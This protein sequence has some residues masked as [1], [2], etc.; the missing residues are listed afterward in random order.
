MV[1]PVNNLRLI[2]LCTAVAAL[3][4]P[5]AAG[6]LRVTIERA[7]LPAAQADPYAGTDAPSTRDGSGLWWSAVDAEHAPVVTMD[8]GGEATRSTSSAWST[9]TPCPRPNPPRRPP[10]TATAAERVMSH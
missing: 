10:I 7:G 8:D 5:A 2:L 3:A 6:A 4:Q 9:S 1:L